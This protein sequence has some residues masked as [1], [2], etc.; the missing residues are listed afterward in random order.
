MLLNSE[1]QKHVDGL[2]LRFA[3]AH[4]NQYFGDKNF[5]RS[6]IIKAAEDASD[7]LPE[8]YRSDARE[9]AVI[10]RFSSQVFKHLDLDVRIA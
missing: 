3:T 8:A 6:D 5:R 10:W 9:L 2:T 7:N 1:D 4:S